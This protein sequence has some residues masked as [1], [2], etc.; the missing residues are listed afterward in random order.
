MSYLPAKLSLEDL[1][2]TR[3]FLL[4]DKYIL[5]CYSLFLITWPCVFP[6][7]LICL[8]YAACYR[9]ARRALY[10]LTGLAHTCTRA[11]PPP[12]AVEHDNER[13][14][15]MNNKYTRT[16]QTYTIIYDLNIL[17]NIFYA[18]VLPIFNNV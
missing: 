9:D 7:A 2:S 18:N 17:S 14:R 11:V 12:H 4:L 5:A 16:L 10:I 3:L 8:S 1:E 6:L 15:A 13:Y